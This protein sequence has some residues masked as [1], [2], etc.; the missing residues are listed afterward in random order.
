MP[1]RSSTRRRWLWKHRHRKCHYCGQRLVMKVGGRYSLTVD[2]LVPKS[3]GGKDR[4]SNL[5]ACCYACNQA[6][7]SRSYIEFTQIV[8]V[9][10]K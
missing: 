7:A 6:K 5:V 2:H 9:A 1:D 8:A 10:L 3:R 4:R